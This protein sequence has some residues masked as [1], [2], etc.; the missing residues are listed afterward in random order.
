[1]NNQTSPR[2][3]YES[4][5]ISRVINAMGAVTFLGGLPMDPRVI[6]A[7][8]TA[9][10]AKVDSHELADAI[11]ARLSDLLGVEAAMIT[12]GA[13]AGWQLAAAAC[14][15]GADRRAIAELPRVV[16]S[17]DEIAIHRKH[18]GNFD[19]ALRATGARLVEFGYSRDRTEG[20]EFD[21]VLGERTAGAAYVTD[22]GDDSVLGL[23]EF[24]GRAHAVGVPVIVDAAVSLPPAENLR[25]IPTT[26][27][28]LVAFSGGKALGGPQNT[29]LLVGRADLIAHCRANTAPNHNTIGRGMKVSA[30]AA[31]GLL[32][33]IELYL[34]RDHEADHR[35]WLDAVEH[36]RGA[37]AGVGVDAR[38]DPT[39]HHAPPIP[40]LIVDGLSDPDAIAAR[41]AADSPSIRV[42]RHGDAITVCP[43]AI[44]PRD[45][46]YVAERL[47]AA[48]TGATA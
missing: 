17:R 7:M 28:D 16:G 15:T 24:I 6:D 37:L 13:A 43:H 48:V 18:R 9:A 8:S 20:W 2:D 11:S 39:P 23:E 1:M 46:D 3:P 31:V 35:S 22:Y 27:A 34:E 38:V 30:E 45:L 5:G 21:A 29:G 32:V 19:H 36:M 47:A 40:T 42:G 25:G 33:A 10:R 4:L 14:L 12:S 41:L 44:E 26:G